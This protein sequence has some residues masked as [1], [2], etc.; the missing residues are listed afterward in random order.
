MDTPVLDGWPCRRHSSVGDKL[1]VRL[2]RI[3]RCRRPV[4]FSLSVVLQKVDSRCL[5]FFYVL[6]L[7]VLHIMV[8]EMKL[9]HV[10]A[11]FFPYVIGS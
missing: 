8:P 10:G 3:Y 7:A 5:L 11:P 1:G 4:A 6:P 2:E 9:L